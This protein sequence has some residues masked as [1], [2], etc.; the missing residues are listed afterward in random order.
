MRFIPIL[1]IGFLVLPHR[2]GAA[3]TS[4]HS[5]PPFP[6]GEFGRASARFYTMATFALHC[7]P[8]ILPRI[9]SPAESC[10]GGLDELLISLIFPVDSKC[11]V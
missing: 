4:L 1:R 5:S 10:L 3:P 8:S 2:R 11:S 6:R 7:E 9:V